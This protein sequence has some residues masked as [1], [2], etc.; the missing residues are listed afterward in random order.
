MTGLFRSILG[1]PLNIWKCDCGHTDS[2]AHEE[3]VER[4]IET[5]MNP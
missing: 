4:A 3:L 2:V 1:H 5:L